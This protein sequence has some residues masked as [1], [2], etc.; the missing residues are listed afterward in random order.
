E[1]AKPSELWGRFPPNAL[2]AVA[3]RVDFVALTEVL[4]EFM[5]PDARKGVQV[6]MKRT[7]G[8]L[9]MDLVK[10]VLPYVGPDW[11]LCVIASAEKNA[12]PCVI[13]ALRVQAGPP[14]AAVDQALFK[15]VHTFAFFGVFN[16]NLAS[17]PSDRLSLKE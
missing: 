17:S 16:Y 1:A 6:A 13:W 8:T 7:W 15:A 10:D 3:G 11:G 4:G 9:G 14:G 12:F 5:T 2:L